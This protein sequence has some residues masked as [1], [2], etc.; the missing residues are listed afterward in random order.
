MKKLFYRVVGGSLALA[1]SLVLAADVSL[2]DYTQK[3]LPGTSGTEAIR[4][5]LQKAANIVATVV[6]AIAV[7]YILVSA[8][9]FITA[10]GDEEKIKTARRQLIY[11]LV[12][13]AVSL[14]AF[15]MP[16]IIGGF[17]A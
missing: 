8:Y 1:P 2:P 12:G 4:A 11:A 5:T 17:L 3:Q 16:S 7:I 15:S 13:I 6:L 10:G 14:L 9:N